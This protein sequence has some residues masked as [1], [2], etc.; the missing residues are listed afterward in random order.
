MKLLYV[1]EHLSCFNY[2]AGN[3]TL[4]DLVNVK[5][6]EYVEFCPQVNIIVFILE[7]KF[8]F[9][10]GSYLNVAGKAKD[11]F[12]HPAGLNCKVVAESDVTIMYMQMNT[13]LSFCDH[14]SFEMLL[15]ENADE[16]EDSEPYLHMLEAN[17]RVEHFLNGLADYI[18]DGL[19]CSYLMEMKIKEVLYLLRAYYTKEELKLFFKP[20]LNNDLTFSMRVN[21]LYNSNIS[22]QEL[23]KS[24]NYSLS[25]FEKKFKRVFGT[26]ANKWLQMKRAQSI[27]H[28]INCSTKT[29]SELAYEYNFSSPAHFNTFC[30]KQFNITPGNLRKRYLSEK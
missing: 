14:F 29:F 30:R 25:G 16:K 28:D 2:S 6:G 18:T 23:S 1:E 13:D 19:R 12:I 10:Y 8:N 9:S 4:I 27:Y 20:I 5:Y 17:A 26:T 7:G 21:N 11:I 15:Q 24:L 22:V 3:K